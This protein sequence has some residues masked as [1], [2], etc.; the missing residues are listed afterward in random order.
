M[1]YKREKVNIKKMTKSTTNKL[2]LTNIILVIL[3]LI[4]N[5]F[6]TELGLTDSENIYFALVGFIVFGIS[7]GGVFV[8]F[9]ER[10]E[11][12][13]KPLI[14]L[15]GNS[16]LTLFFLITFFYIALTMEM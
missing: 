9:K 6:W 1:D 11:K 16:I 4:A 13:N 15:I 14:G 3:A 8:G 5:E 2:L 10:K 7:A 12:V